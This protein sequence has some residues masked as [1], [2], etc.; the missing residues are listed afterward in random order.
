METDFPLSGALHPRQLFFSRKKAIQT[1]QFMPQ[2]ARR[3]EKVRVGI[4]YSDL[5]FNN[6]LK[7]YSTIR[8]W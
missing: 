2:G 6:S 4:G 7:S 8:T 5:L 3:E 1:E